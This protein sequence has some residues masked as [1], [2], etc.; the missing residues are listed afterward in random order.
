MQGALALLVSIIVA[1]TGKPSTK[2]PYSEEGRQT[3]AG[4]KKVNASAYIYIYFYIYIEICMCTC[5]LV[6]AY[7]CARSKRGECKIRNGAISRGM[8]PR[9]AQSEPR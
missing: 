3:G 7:I 5:W 9:R 6:W 4:C 8:L 2:A 1:G